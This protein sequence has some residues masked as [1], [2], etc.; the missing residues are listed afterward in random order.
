MPGV[1]VENIYADICVTPAKDD[2]LVLR[3]PSQY[4]YESSIHFL[5]KI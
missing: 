2:S 1:V 4:S 3:I 5:E